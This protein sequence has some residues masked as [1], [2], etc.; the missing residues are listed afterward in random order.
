MRDTV[1]PEMA[2]PVDLARRTGRL[3]RVEYER[4]IEAGYFLPSDKVELIDGLLVAREPQRSPHATGIMLGNEA[5]RAAFGAGWV[6]R[7]QLPIALDE[8][9]EPEPDLVVVRGTVRDF[10][11]SHPDAVALIVEVA[12]SS[13]RFNR[14]DKAS[15]YA[16]ARVSDYWIV[17]LTDRVVEVHRDPRPAPAAA[18]G[19]HY[20]SIRPA[21]P[22]DTVTPL[23]LPES[24]VRVADLLP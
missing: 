8:D 10:T 7:V 19:W 22:G 23:A 18:Y 12:D 24:S 3:K 21:R 14:T 16:R 1:V 9:S 17:N 6:V 2:R 13:L 4:L 11:R 15:L 5:L 20:G